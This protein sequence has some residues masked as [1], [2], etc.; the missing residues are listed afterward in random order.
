MSDSAS[1][2]NELAWD[3]VSQVLTVTEELRVEPVENP[4]GACHIDFGVEAPGSLAAGLALAEVCTAGLAEIHIHPGELG[5]IPWPQIF[6]TTDSPVEA[7]LLSQY[8]GWRI[9]VGKYFAMGSGPMR[10]AA[11][12]EALFEEFEFKESGVG[13]VGVLEASELP[14]PDA[15]RQIATACGCEPE[16]LALLVAPTAST[17]GSIK[18]VAR[19]I[20]TA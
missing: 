5:G 19:C 3:L 17:A 4:A 16:Q 18:I 1:S 11:A 14:T 12:T 2:L 13:A 9:S 15:V 10:A 6:V 7:C 20:E 8:A